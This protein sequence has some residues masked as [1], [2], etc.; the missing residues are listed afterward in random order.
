[1]TTDDHAGM[2]A[3]GDAKCCW[4]STRC[5]RPVARTKWHREW[6]QGMGFPPVQPVSELT[7]SLGKR[8]A[9]GARYSSNKSQV[10][11]SGWR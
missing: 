9:D 1:M 7:T 11:F 5:Y 10:T 4:L 2:P 6:T 8:N 3:R